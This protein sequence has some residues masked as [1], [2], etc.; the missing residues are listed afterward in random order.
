[1]TTMKRGESSDDCLPKFF[2]VYLPGE[3]G[4]DLELP[5]S[6]NSYLPKHLPRTVTVSCISGKNWTL[7]L[8]KCSVD[9]Y[10]LVNGWKRIVKDECLTGGEFIEFEFDGFKCFN[11]CIY[12]GDTMCKRLGR[13]SVDSEEIKEESDD[14]VIVID[15]DD[16]VDYDI[17]DDIEYVE[18]DDDDDDEAVDDDDVRQYLDDCNNPFF[19]M[20]LNPKKKSQLH[21]PSQVIRDYGL[22]F[23]ESITV[24][25]PLAK[26]F[27]TLENAIKIQVNGSVF[28]KKFGSVIRRNNVK[29]TD[30]LV[31]ELKK[32]GNSPVHTIKVS[33]ING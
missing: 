21:I 9:K 17:A 3:S 22:N 24:V 28:V 31:C 5:A 32:T 30:K 11:F 29:L 8:R 23:S 16:D 10:V 26:K 14:D 20:K 4:D 15:S 25:D 19:T 6:L 1:M 7:A 18:D 27:G 33:I 13:N 12:E 2:K